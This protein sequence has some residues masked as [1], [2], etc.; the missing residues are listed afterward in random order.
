MRDDPDAGRKEPDWAYEERLLGEGVALV[1]GIDEVGRG[2]IAG[3]VAAGA[4]ILDPRRPPAWW[5]DVRDS[6]LLTPG[7]RERLAE[8]IWRD[9]VAVGVGSASPREIDTIG[10]APASRLAMVRAI[11]MLRRPPAHLLLDCFRL[12]ESDLPQTPILHG[13]RIC[14]SVAAASIVAKVARDRW[15]VQLDERYP[16]YGFASHKGYSSPEHLEALDRLGPCPL[17]RRSFRPDRFLQFALRFEGAPAGAP[18][19]V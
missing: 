9:A 19:P 18:V 1:A 15:M 2:P 4:V 10:I 12:P 16:G 6:K 17:H 7:Q 8:L 13:D 11:A 3:A 14:V 5:A